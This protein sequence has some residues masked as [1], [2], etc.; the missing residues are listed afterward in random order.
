MILKQ[1]GHHATSCS[2][3]RMKILLRRF[4]KNITDRAKDTQK[5]TDSVLSHCISKLPD[6]AHIT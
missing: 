5:T 4:H 1:H 6:S 3:D 2:R